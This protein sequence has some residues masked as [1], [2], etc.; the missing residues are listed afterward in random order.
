[1]KQ[2]TLTGTDV[3]QERL[4]ESTVEDNFG[5]VF[6]HERNGRLRV[7]DLHKV[8]IVAI[9]VARRHK[10]EDIHTRRQ[11]RPTSLNI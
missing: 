6:L 9:F 7:V 1:M 4:L 10:A 8:C 11:C 2:K 3:I 5:S